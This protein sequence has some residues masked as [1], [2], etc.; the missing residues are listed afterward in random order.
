MTD[1]LTQDSLRLAQNLPISTH[2]SYFT[3]DL[4]LAI[5][6]HCITSISWHHV[7]DTAELAVPGTDEA[8]LD[9]KIVDDQLEQVVTT[10]LAD[11]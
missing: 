9:T 5:L 10:G 1:S 4:S 11:T 2:E 8:S 7:V 6:K 3:L